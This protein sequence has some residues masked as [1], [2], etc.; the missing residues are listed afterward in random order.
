MKI[1]LI[2]NKDFLLAMLYNLSGTAFI[3]ENDVSVMIAKTKPRLTFK[4]IKRKLGK[5]NA[6]EIMIRLD[7]WLYK[8]SYRMILS[9]LFPER[10]ISGLRSLPNVKFL[11]YIDPSEF[12]D[13]P[14]YDYMIIATYSKKISEEVINTPKLG[15]LN[16]HPSRLPE[17]RGGYPT[18]VEAFQGA[19]RSSATL[20]VMSRLFDAGDIVAQD[21]Q[22][23]DPGA[24]NSVRYYES[25]KI[26]ARLLDDWYRSGCKTERTQ[27]DSRQISYCHKT[28]TAMKNVRKMTSSDNL[29][30]FTKANYIKHLFPFTYLVQGLS[31]WFIMEV[32][33]VINPGVAMSAYKS[34]KRNLQLFSHH[35]HLYL[36][37]FDEL[38]LIK[39]Y[40]KRGRLFNA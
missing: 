1:L 6:D 24:T 34:K 29:E 10:D 22:P 14:L 28:L 25:S 12:T 40:I 20:H 32:E 8:D 9:Q 38:Y 36:W 5:V 16:I 17:L 3:R 26:A 33:K 30:R 35:D 37:F 31:C 2:G 27:Q 23:V 7:Q 19:D 4:S 18:Y 11:P 39:R 13:L 21:S 15:T